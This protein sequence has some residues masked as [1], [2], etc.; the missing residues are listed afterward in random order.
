M[1][2]QVLKSAIQM[3]IVNSGAQIWT[4]AKSYTGGPTWLFHTSSQLGHHVLD[5]VRKLYSA[6]SSAVLHMLGGQDWILWGKQGAEPHP[7]NLK[8]PTAWEPI[9]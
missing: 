8:E 1:T 2:G 6:D 7:R 4:I 5:L 9:T 3:E